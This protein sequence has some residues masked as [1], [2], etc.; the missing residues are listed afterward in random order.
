ML[1]IESLGSGYGSLQV[2]WDI[3]LEVRDGEMVALVGANG[4]GKTT[5]LNT[6]SGLI[7][8]FNGDI[9]FQGKSVL[10][11]SPGQRV[12]RGIVQVPEGRKLW[13]GMTV[14]ENLEMGAFRR[15]ETAQIRR[16]LGWVYDLFP[17]V[18]SRKNQ[19]AGTLSGGEQQMVAIGRAL[20]GAPRLLLIDELSLGL[21]PVVVDRIVSIV[22]RIR[23]ELRIDILLVEQDVRLALGI[24]DR[25]YVLETGHIRAEGNAHQ[26]LSDDAVKSAYLGI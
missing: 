20:M 12:E 26:L 7:R 23:E 8:P 11:C 2:L 16:D 24:S 22:E 5:L 10:R 25:A 9:I 3:E 6:I 13:S 18:V 21:A 15:R 1:K 17:E 14:N 4:A 19:L